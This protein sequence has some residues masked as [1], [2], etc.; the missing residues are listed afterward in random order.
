MVYTAFPIQCKGKKP[1]WNASLTWYRPPRSPQAPEP[2]DIPPQIRVRMLFQSDRAGTWGEVV[3]TWLQ[4]SFVM[5]T[6]QFKRVPGYPGWYYYPLA[7]SGWRNTFGAVSDT[8]VSEFGG[9]AEQLYM[10]DGTPFKMVSVGASQ[11][12]IDDPGYSIQIN[13]HNDEISTL[14][15]ESDYIGTKYRARNEVIWVECWSQ[16]VSKVIAFVKTFERPARDITY[17]LVGCYPDPDAQDVPPP[18]P[19][20]YGGRPPDTQNVKELLSTSRRDSKWQIVKSVYLKDTKHG[21]EYFPVPPS[22]EH[23]LIG[24][25]FLFCGCADNEHKCGGCCLACCEIAAMMTE[26]TDAREWV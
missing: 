12:L 25:S 19:G 3:T 24:A 10:S 6:V 15:W 17:S 5:S 11:S 13:P 18:P 20:G 22:D 4:K 21:T 7:P 26:K 2:D 23:R 16:D 1:G 14:Y 9:N 8:F